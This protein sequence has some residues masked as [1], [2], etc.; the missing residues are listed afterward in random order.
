MPV[1]V[2]PVSHAS[3]KWR[4][5][6]AAESPEAL[7][8]GSCP[9]ERNRCKWIIQSSFT[10]FSTQPPICPSS[11]GFVQAAIAA[12]CH[13]HHLTIRPD[14]VWLGI[15]NQL[16][17][18]VNAHAEELRSFFV[19]HDD[20]KELEIVEGGNIHSAD[21]G[22]IAE[23]M[24]KLM[25]KNLNDPQ[26][27]PWIMPDF[28]TTK[29][30]DKVVASILM[31]GSMQKY[32]SYRVTLSCGIPSVTLL[33]ER[34]DWENILQRLEKLPHLG[35]EA[36]QFYNLLKPV[37]TYFVASFDTPTAPSIVDFWNKI[38]HE[39]GGSGPTY[40]SGWITAFCFWD[41]DGK[42]LYTPP[43]TRP[44]GPV[45]IE[46]FR[47][48]N[49]GCDLNGTLYHRIDTNL[50]PGGFA[51]VPVKLND[52]GRLYDTVMVAGSVGI[53]VTS[54]G[55]LLYE[56]LRSL[57]FKMGHNGER[58]LY[59]HGPASPTGNPGPDSLQP[60]LGWWMY[61]KAGGEEGE[62]SGARELSPA[63]EVVSSQKIREETTAT[64]T[65]RPSARLYET[66][67]LARL[68]G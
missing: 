32:F 54:S 68:P 25:V 29:D 31:M 12:Y 5:A 8:Q 47:H 63:E 27:L 20:R 26:L 44:S 14:D 53:Q 16:S 18:F 51:S 40:L 1:T 13:H 67:V 59:L 22:A 66:N 10:G 35:S 52:N 65:I 60:V 9:K 50:I 64:T 61:E 19:S 46:G 28:S 17:F 58:I 55:Q 23:R 11:N 36:G 57:R 30:T 4:K 38:A 41:E 21:F 48:G 49:P 34:A 45:Q 33:G 56:D 39:S 3:K 6:E 37:L 42:S 2:K 24:T 62:A 43:R 15:L 7:L